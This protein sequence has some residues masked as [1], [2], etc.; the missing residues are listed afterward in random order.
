MERY[1]D[2]QGH[3]ATMPLPGFRAGAFYVDIRGKADI[4][5]S[6]EFAFRAPFPDG[7]FVIDGRRL[8]AGEEH[9]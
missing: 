2:P 3:K 8:T 4:M 9:F 6:D 1:L 7:A 5:K